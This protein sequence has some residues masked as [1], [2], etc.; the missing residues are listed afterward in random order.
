MTSFYLLNFGGCDLELGVNWLE[1]LDPITGD[2]SKQS[3]TF[4][5]GKGTIYLKGLLL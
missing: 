2:F 5:Y 1:T 3:T 4:N